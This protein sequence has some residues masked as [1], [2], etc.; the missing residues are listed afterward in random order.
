M[1]R[2]LCLLAAV[3]LL[4]SSVSIATE[5]KLLGIKKVQ[6]TGE[7]DE[8]RVGTGKGKFNRIKLRVK[9]GDVE[10]RDVKVKF[11]NGETFDVP[12]RSTIEAGGETRRIDL[13]GEARI[14][15]KIILVYKTKA[16]SKSATVSVWGEK[17]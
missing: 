11:A 7:L 16:G 2:M 17:E 4:S 5:W 13:P 14:I 12:M 6:L 10:F 1:K 3:V 15:D 8:I 9:D